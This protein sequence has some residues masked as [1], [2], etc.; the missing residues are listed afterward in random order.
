MKQDVIISIRHPFAVKIYSGAKLYEFRKRRPN[1]AVGTR[2]WIY[3][4]LPIGKV[5]GFFIYGGCYR[6]EKAKVWEHCQEAAG[7]SREAF[8]QYYDR[9][10]Y[11]YAWQVG[12][13]RRCPAFDLK[14]A[15]IDRAP[16]S[17]ITWSSEFLDYLI[18]MMNERKELNGK[19]YDLI[20]E[21]LRGEKGFA[22][23]RVGNGWLS[24]SELI[25]DDGKLVMIKPWEPDSHSQR[26]HIMLKV[27][28]GELESTKED[29]DLLRF[30]KFRA[31]SALIKLM[32]ERR[33]QAVVVCE[34]GSL[35]AI[36]DDID[37][38][39]TWLDIMLDVFEQ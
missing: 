13:A 27:N 39:V 19:F 6:D 28:P 34:K 35:T 3:E 16:Q 2:C 24:M 36:P 1:I 22:T 33:A 5:T 30:V 9:D 20:H 14:D 32:M 11:A 15:G 25:K 7:I 29:W 38:L 23:C 8:M 37:P 26:I 18:I 31:S 10:F 17:Y 12:T 4:P 21:I